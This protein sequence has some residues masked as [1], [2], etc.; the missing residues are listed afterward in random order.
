MRTT[1]DVVIFGAHPDDVE[2]AMGGTAAKLVHAGFS[3][4]SVSL[5]PS[6][7]STF[8]DV[9]TRAREFQNANAILGTHGR[10]LNFLDTQIENTPAARVEIARLIR[11]TRPRLLFAPYHTNPFTELGGIA[12]VDHYTT[13]ALVRDAAK[14]ARIEKTVPELPRHTISQL[15]YYMLPEHIRPTI[16]V[17]VTDTFDQALQAIRAYESQMRIQ[18]A[19]NEIERILT[20]RRAAA[21]IPIGAS[22]AENFLAEL[23]L[24][25]TPELFFAV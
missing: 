15:F 1:Y 21:G 5:T 6:E 16:T 4:L 2:M 9:E 7:M 25:F 20:L 14:I 24:R 12:N 19:G 10:I 23:P 22:Y 8:G 13:G 18:L 17:D 3:V 11:E